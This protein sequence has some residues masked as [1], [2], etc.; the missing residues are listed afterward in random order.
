[1]KIILQVMNLSRR[2]R[3]FYMKFSKILKDWA[4]LLLAEGQ[5][6][7]SPRKIKQWMKYSTSV[8][9]IRFVKARQLAMHKTLYLHRL[10]YNRADLLDL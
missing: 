7:W 3:P 2:H 5:A 10:Q 6:C 1:M 9:M 8:A 4:Q